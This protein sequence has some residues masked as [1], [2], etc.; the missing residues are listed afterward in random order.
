M[1]GAA[2][3]LHMD[4]SLLFEPLTL[5]GT[6]FANRIFLAPMCQY[7]C[8]AQDGMPTDWHLV[9]LGS[10][11]IGGFGLIITEATAVNPE[12][13]ISPQD[14]GIWNA[15]Q[16]QAWRRINDFLHNHGSAT[17]IQLAHAGRKAS[18]YSPFGGG[19]GSVPP[20]EGG[21]E[22]V[23]PSAEAFDGYR[24][25]RELT[26]A[27]IAGIVEDFRAAA[28]RSDAADF[29][30]V[31]IH[32]AHGYLLHQFLSPLSNHRTDGYG[33]NFE[34]RSRLL[35]EV[36]G[37]VRSVWPASKPLF[38]RFSGTDWTQDGWTLEDTVRASALVGELGAD[39][40]DVSSGGNVPK[41]DIP[42]GPGYQVPLAAGVRKATGLPVGA[43]GLITDPVQAEQILSEGA[44]DVV[45]LARAGLR[46]P[47]WPQRA[48]HEL[49]LSTDKA[50]YRPQYERG[51]WR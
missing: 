37:A 39:L 29:D 4:M 28:V 21:W 5:R 25:P 14:T 6:T 49:G 11:A 45:L 34:G 10:H 48:A 50:P 51:A 7:S 36:V 38:V 33:G 27:E 46:E 26:V 20:A 43:V 23:G 22:T 16:Q 8:E 12:G 1:A 41:A 3:S 35:R 44:A 9:H 19:S 2:R 15:E 30:V 18:T 32:A 31:E 13:R 17:G 47:G 40:I 42:V 24:T